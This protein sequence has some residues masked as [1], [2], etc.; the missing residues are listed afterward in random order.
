MVALSRSATFILKLL[1]S[2]A[3]VTWL[4][5]KVKWMAVL[6]YVQNARAADLIL[7]T[8]LLLS[9]M[10]IS[11]SK[12]QTI[13]QFRGFQRS[14]SQCFSVYLTGTF[15]NNFLPSFIGG[16][17][18]RVYWLGKQNGQYA[19][20]ISTVILDRLTG[21]GA[22]ILLTLVFSLFHVRAVV[23]NPVWLAC[24]AL[25]FVSLV[26]GTMLPRV[27]ALPWT[28]APLLRPLPARLRRL[29]QELRVYDSQPLLLPVFLSSLAFNFVG[30][31]LANFVL[32]E[33]LGSHVAFADYM[34]VVFL[35]SIVSS[36]PITINNIGLKEWAYF[37]FFGFLG[38]DPE[39]AITVAIVS[40]FIQLLV[41]FFALPAYLKSRRAI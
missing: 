34:A 2:L 27:L 12:W 11:A 33:A 41:S 20:A 13:V 19:P 10:I 5:F 6:G 17:A 39:A 32:F 26:V 22:A 25:L 31:G 35:V 8:L 36:L 24:V 40:R 9:G 7:Y 21:L 38:A 4:V 16:D 23:K 1:I 18:Y 28:Q 30:V 15:I 3:F 14:I 29:I 37:T